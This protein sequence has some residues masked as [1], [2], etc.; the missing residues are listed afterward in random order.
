MVSY[1]VIWMIDIEADSP[2]EA[3]EEALRIHRDPESIA[4]V[5]EILDK[6]TD[7]TTIID[8]NPEEGG[9]EE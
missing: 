3:A 1:L 9:T 5:F 7:V 4:T 2:Q 8:L 6:G